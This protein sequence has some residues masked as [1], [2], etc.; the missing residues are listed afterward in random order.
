[1]CVIQQTL[2]AWQSDLFLVVKS[3]FQNLFFF[4]IN[5]WRT[6]AELQCTVTHCIHVLQHYTF[7]ECMKTACL[8]S[9]STLSPS[10]SSKRKSDY[11]TR[12]VF[13]VLWKLLSAAWR[14]NRFVLHSWEW[15]RTSCTELPTLTLTSLNDQNM[16]KMWTKH[17]WYWLCDY[18]FAVHSS[19]IWKLLRRPQWHQ[20][21]P[22]KCILINSDNNDNR[23]LSLLAS[24]DHHL[25]SVVKMATIRVLVCH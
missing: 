5:F 7:Q 15:T 23:A 20:R 11:A 14:Q 17:F 21:S 12:G 1:M 6:K 19:R 2:K 8:R 10:V 16:D 22:W 3:S 25:I 13:S 4:Y 24:Q 18:E 9:L